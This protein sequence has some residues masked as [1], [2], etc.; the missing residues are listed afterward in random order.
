M[1]Y[2]ELFFSFF[3]GLYPL[4]LST[5]QSKM[6]NFG[7]WDCMFVMG[8]LDWFLEGLKH[9]PRFG[10]LLQLEHGHMNDFLR[11]MSSSCNLILFV[12]HVI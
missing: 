11:S 10:F 2:N 4:F 3:C 8:G 5:I 7:L 9:F 1:I 6:D 12:K